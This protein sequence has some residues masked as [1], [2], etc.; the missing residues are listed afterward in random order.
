MSQVNQMKMKK[1]FR[2]MQGRTRRT[3]KSVEVWTGIRGI[4]RDTVLINKLTSG[5]FS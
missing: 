4:G 3:G 5:I 2:G 1:S